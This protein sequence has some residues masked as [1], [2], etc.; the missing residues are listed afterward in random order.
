MPD[1]KWDIERLSPGERSA[2]RRCAGITMGSSVQAIEAF[3]HALT[4]YCPSRETEKIWFA[5]L[6]MECLWR[7]EDHPSRKPFEEIARRMYQDPKSTESLKRRCTAYLDLTWGDDGFLLGKLCNLVRMMRA[8]N[9]SIMPD[10]DKLADDLSHWDRA[11]RSVQRR[12][13]RMI[14]MHD[15]KNEADN[16]KEVT[17][18]AD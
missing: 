15:N 7:P 10:F 6:C 1:K 4:T 11:D 9:S 2:L 16:D 3:Y 17:E 13:L 12:W 14:C 5:S 8:N 18:N